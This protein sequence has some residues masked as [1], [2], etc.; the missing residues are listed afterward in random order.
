MDEELGTYQQELTGV[1][2]DFLRPCE[3]RVL[4]RRM[5]MMIER[6][7]Q[8]PRLHESYFALGLVKCP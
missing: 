8:P 3:Y 4:M 1:T 6:A 2:V 5:K 7:G